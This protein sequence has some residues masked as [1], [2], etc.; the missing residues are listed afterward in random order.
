MNLSVLVI[1][2]FSG[3]AGAAGVVMGGAVELSG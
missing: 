2:G 1:V 3:E